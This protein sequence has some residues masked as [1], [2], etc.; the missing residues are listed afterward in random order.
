MR[1][2]PDA[3]PTVQPKRQKRSLSPTLTREEEEAATELSTMYGNIMK[4]CDL[5]RRPPTSDR[6]PLLRRDE[7]TLQLLGGAKAATALKHLKSQ[8]EH[9]RIKYGV[10]FRWGTMVE[11]TRINTLLRV[12]SVH[13]N[14][15][16]AVHANGATEALNKGTLLELLGPSPPTSGGGVGRVAGQEK[17]ATV[18]IPEA[19]VRAL[20]NWFGVRASPGTLWLVDARDAERQSDVE[21]TSR[22]THVLEWWWAQDR[23]QLLKS[24][25]PRGAVDNEICHVH[26]IMS[27]PDPGCRKFEKA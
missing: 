3:P 10:H 21:V 6:V 5:L 11:R 19:A 2:E 23:E 9:A 1:S 15:E 24:L 16:V 17:Y 27:L 26:S 12:Y 25:S 4:I 14:A 20:K 7:L 13:P 8:L 18:F 22:V